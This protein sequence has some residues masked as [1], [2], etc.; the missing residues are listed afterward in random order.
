ML[1]SVQARALLE[2]AERIRAKA[3]AEDQ[4]ELGKLSERVKVA[5]SERNWKGLT[6]A[7]DDLA[8]VLFYLED[9]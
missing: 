9:V 1:E 8:Q 5:L 3:N 6:S 2:K 4:A 7:C